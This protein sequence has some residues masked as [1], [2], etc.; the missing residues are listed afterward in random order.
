MNKDELLELLQHPSSLS[1]DQLDELKHL[2]AEYPYFQAPYALL[3]KITQKGTDI[4]KAAVRSANRISL[5]RFINT[6]YKADTK[7]PDFDRIYIDPTS[8]NAFERLSD[9]SIPAEKE[10]SKL[11]EEYPMQL[12]SETIDSNYNKELSLPSEDEAAPSK[13]SDDQKIT[14]PEEIASSAEDSPEIIY[15]NPYLEDDPFAPVNESEEDVYNDPDKELRDELMA[16]LEEFKKVRETSEWASL[17]SENEEVKEDKPEEL[18]AQEKA[19]EH[20][21]IEEKVPEKAKENV[22][23]P[24]PHYFSSDTDFQVPDYKDEYS[25]DDLP[26]D[27]DPKPVFGNQEEIRKLQDL[28]YSIQNRPE[29]EDKPFSPTEFNKKNSWEVSP[30]FFELNALLEETSKEE[31]PRK[32]HLPDTQPE[33]QFKEPTLSEIAQKSEKAEKSTQAAY[34]ENSAEKEVESSLSFGSSSNN[35]VEVEEKPKAGIP[36]QQQQQHIIDR[37]IRSDKGIRIEANDDENISAKSYQED[38]SAQ[39]EYSF[40]ASENLAHIFKRQRK[41]QKAIDLYEELILK[42]PEKRSY[43]AGQIEELQNLKGN[44]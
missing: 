1:D 30:D 39:N 44:V 21:L 17:N 12:S 31:K 22:P 20:Y 15:E 37:F 7:L 16:N 34:Q 11:E 9:H 26:S 35:L 14:E 32:D 24:D 4:E 2:I 8:V 38:L 18:F 43:F 10:A 13:I 5:K 3:A 41:Y 27:K 23:D 36:S 42:Y 29:A 40:Q 28:A 25:F 6:D 33:P 19:T